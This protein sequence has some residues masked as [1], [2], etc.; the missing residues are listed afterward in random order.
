[1]RFQ[2]REIIKERCA[3]PVRATIIPSNFIFDILLHVN[4]WIFN[5]QIQAA[6][7]APDPYERSPA[8]HHGS[9]PH[10]HHG[11]TGNVRVH[12]IPVH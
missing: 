8:D 6:S 3:V 10:L 11:A 4:N 12:I 2:H 1:M 7:A 5:K 9:C